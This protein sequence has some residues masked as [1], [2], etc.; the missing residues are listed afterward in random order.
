MSDLRKSPRDDSIGGGPGYLWGAS[1]DDSGRGSLRISAVDASALGPTQSAPLVTAAPSPS[2][3]SP[4]DIALASPAGASQWANMPNRTFECYFPG[5]TEK[6]FVL[7]NNNPPIFVNRG[8]NGFGEEVKT[9]NSL[10]DLPL[11]S[12]NANGKPDWTVAAAAA[13]DP[14][15]VGV[16]WLM[17]KT[18]DEDGMD[19]WQLVSKFQGERSVLAPCRMDF[20]HWQK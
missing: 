20:E 17:V 14:H 15:L 19:A 5:G 13:S 2:T 11:T 7:P 12:I 9:V 1:F 16:Q 18:I 8:K 3:P 10:T 4:A 6:V